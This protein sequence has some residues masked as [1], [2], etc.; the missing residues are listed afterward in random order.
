M[1]EY[2]EPEC[3]APDLTGCPGC[4]APAEVTDRFDL[5]GTD[6]PVEHVSVQ[7]ASRHVF[8]LP[9]DR[10]PALP[11]PAADRPGRWTSPLT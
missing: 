4:A 2:P 5:W 11:A 6:G 9:A 1:S 8:T 3:P 10:L 7:C